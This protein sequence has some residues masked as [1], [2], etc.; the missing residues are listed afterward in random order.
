MPWKEAPDGMVTVWSPLLQLEVRFADGQLRFWDPKT[1]RY[2]E[3]PEADAEAQVE[4]TEQALNSEKQARKVLEARIAEI[5]AIPK[6]PRKHTQAPPC[7]W[8]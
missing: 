2:L 7:G 3:P 4:S 5:E 8:K 1:A 6:S